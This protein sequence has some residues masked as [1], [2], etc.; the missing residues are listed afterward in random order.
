MGSIQRE[1]STPSRR[2]VLIP[3]QKQEVEGTPGGGDEFPSNLN[4][5]ASAPSQHQVMGRAPGGGAVRA[6]SI[7]P[8][9]A[10]GQ[11]SIQS[12]SPALPPASENV[13]EPLSASSRSS[14]SEARNE[15][16]EDFSLDEADEE[17]EEE[18]D[19]EH[20]EHEGVVAEEED[21]SPD[22]TAL[23]SSDDDNK[24]NGDGGAGEPVSKPA[25]RR[26]RASPIAMEPERLGTRNRVKPEIFSP[27]RY[28]RGSSGTSAVAGNSEKRRRIESS[29]EQSQ[30]TEGADSGDGSVGRKNSGARRT[31]NGR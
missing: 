31:K 17:E 27:D 3:P 16:D 29:S 14:S 20:S 6:I 7:D 25:P 24:H 4:T 8:V 2:L 28:N 1:G 19:G 26:R 13:A 15:P 5:P 22:S 23:D 9:T 30:T 12:T 10:V 18:E 11:P 21:F